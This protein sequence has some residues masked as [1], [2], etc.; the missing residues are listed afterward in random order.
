M[1]PVATDVGV[2]TVAV[3]LALAPLRHFALPHEEAMILMVEFKRKLDDSVLDPPFLVE[4]LRVVE[5][6]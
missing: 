6:M 3:T 4:T 2:L 5:V 1:P